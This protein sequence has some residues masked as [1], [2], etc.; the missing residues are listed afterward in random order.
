M[1]D[2][3][4][5]KRPAALRN[6]AVTSLLSIPDASYISRN[7]AAILLSLVE[8]KFP[9]DL[10]KEDQRVILKKARETTHVDIGINL[11]RVLVEIGHPEGPAVIALAIQRACRNEQLGYCQNMAPLIK[12]N[13]DVRD[14]IFA[15]LEKETDPNAGVFIGFYDL[16]YLLPTDEIVPACMDLWRKNPASRSAVRWTLRDSPLQYNVG[17]QE[18]L[19]TLEAEAL[20]EEKAKPKGNGKQP[21]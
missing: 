19:K 15:A 8:S 3:P 14:A 18:A 6:L 2:T 9:P 20:A 10:S 13:R 1:S 7:M 16:V 21:Q 11:A 4:E 5:D 12:K 17:V